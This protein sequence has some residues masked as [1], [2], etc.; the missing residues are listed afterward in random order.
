MFYKEPKMLVQ[1]V[2]PAS[3]TL[4]VHSWTC[5]VAGSAPMVS[6]STTHCSQIREL[7]WWINGELPGREGL[8]CRAVK[9]GAQQGCT[10]GWLQE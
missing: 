7:M 5:H 10:E 9:A 8:I 3:W 2:S 4:Q 6:P 1:A